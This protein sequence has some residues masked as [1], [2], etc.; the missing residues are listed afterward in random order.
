MPTGAGKTTGMINYI[1]KN[2][3]KRYIFVTPYLS[4]CYRIRDACPK[5][6]FIEPDDKFSK[7]QDF[8]LLLA[9][10]N[11]IVT[12]HSL[13][14]FVDSDVNSLI[15]GKKYTLVLDEALNVVEPLSLSKKDIELLISSQT[16]SIDEKLIVSRNDLTYEGKFSDTMREIKNHQVIYWDSSL[17]IK[18]FNPA[19]F[20][21]F[22]QVFILT[23]LFDGS[24]MKSYFELN[25]IDYTY[26]YFS[27]NHTLV[28]GK[29]DDTQF[30]ENANQCIS[31]IDEDDRLND[32]GND[33]QAFSKS[34]FKSRKNKKNI[35]SLQ[36]CAV[37]YL[38]NRCQANVKQ[39]LWTCYKSENK[40]AKGNSI[41]S[42]HGYEHAFIP[43]NQRATNEYSNRTSLAYLV[44]RYPNPEIIK[45][46]S[47]HGISIDRN[48]FALSEM[49]QWVWRSAIRNGKK[50]NLYIPSYRMRHLLLKFLKN[51]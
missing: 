42:L 4:E 50:I 9:A 35:I 15:T 26:S 17:L 44:N 11:N 6:N 33:I 3:D 7:L 20:S 24:L 43:C 1:N 10:G 31:L 21:C 23:Y 16:I 41:I 51:N 14:S 8:K 30:R 29:F 22:H 48:M 47:N 38:K 39:S 28:N 46:F 19:F 25:K 32:I 2:P 40:R 18:L 5:L 36:K 49:V 34:W 27:P 13:L 12:T 37:N 45:F